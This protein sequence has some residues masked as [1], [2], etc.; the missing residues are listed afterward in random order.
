MNNWNVEPEE[1]LV[2]QNELRGHIQLTNGFRSLAEIETIAGVDVAYNSTDWGRAAV[3][4]LAFPSMTL[5]E[6]TVADYE[7]TFPY[8]PGLF[9]FREMPG[10]LAALQRL[11]T[12]PNLII[13]DGQGYAHPRR[14][15]LACHL[16]LYLNLP[17]IGCAKKRL[18]GHFDTPGQQPG[19]YSFL[20][21]EGE[22]VGAVLRTVSKVKPVFVSVGHKVDLITAVD[23]V[24]QCT[25]GYRLPE[26]TRQADILAALQELI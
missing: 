11:Q 2:I 9:S 19:D 12:Q 21:D 15:G 20:L 24:Q 1:A 16:G 13:V 23:I 18:V 4:V 6:Q 26:P 22:M 10:V 17:T 25:R 5:I 8:L 7:V 3:V 14:F